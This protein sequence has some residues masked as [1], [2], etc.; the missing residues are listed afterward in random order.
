MSGWLAGKAPMAQ[1]LP[2]ICIFLLVSISVL[3]PLSLLTKRLGSI[4]PF[5][6]PRSL[7]EDELN[8]FFFDLFSRLLL[9]AGRKGKVDFPRK[10]TRCRESGCAGSFSLSRSFDSSVFG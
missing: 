9:E 6:E 5:T 8:F 10:S 1:W 3:W 2:V 7:M 4:D